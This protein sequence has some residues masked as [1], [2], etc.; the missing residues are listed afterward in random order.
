MPANTSSRDPLRARSTTF[1]GAVAPPAGIT[2]GFLRLD[3]STI[4]V[5]AY[6]I[7][8]TVKPSGKESDGSTDEGRTAPRLHTRTPSQ[9]RRET[10]ATNGSKSVERGAPV[11]DRH[12]AG[13]R[14]PHQRRRPQ[15]TE[16]RTAPTSCQRQQELERRSPTGTRGSA[17]PARTT[18][19]P[20][21]SKSWSAGL[22]PASRGSAKPAPMTPA[23]AN[24][25]RAGAPVSDRIARERAPTTRAARAAGLR[26]SKPHQPLPTAARAGAPVSD[27]HRAGARNLHQRRRPQ[28]T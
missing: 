5:A 28:P 10:R 13:A 15:P 20:P 23:P 3:A 11:S 6:Q 1:S 9:H 16:S 21:I 4:K 7:S 25:A 18:P 27:R 2:V 17:K 26:R 22:R 12:R 14:N 24:A 8:P 19:A